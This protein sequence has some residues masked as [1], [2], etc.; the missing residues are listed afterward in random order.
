MDPEN[1]TGVSPTNTSTP[2]SFSAP[3]AY[4]VGPLS[5][6]PAAPIG[7]ALASFL[8][9]IVGGNITVPS[10]TDFAEIDKNLAVF[11]QDDWKI[12]RDEHSRR[13]QLFLY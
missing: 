12:T 7:Q 11:I 2:L 13:K 6:A 8:Y 1:R 9:G 3:T 4:T 10:T 5:N